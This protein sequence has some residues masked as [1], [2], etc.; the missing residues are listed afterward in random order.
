MMCLVMLSRSSLTSSSN[1]KLHE[2]LQVPV[3]PGPVV[4]LERDPVFVVVAPVS[5][6][7]E[8]K[9]SDDVGSASTVLGIVMPS[10]LNPLSTQYMSWRP[11]MMLTSVSVFMFAKV[12]L[13]DAQRVME[14]IR[15]SRLPFLHQQLAW[16][17]PYCCML[18]HEGL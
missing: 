17:Q 4:R 7:L 9:L 12:Q 5:D 18:G 13:V 1:R 2:N 8:N 16:S 6:A 10:G 14:L 15:R 11:E 3:S